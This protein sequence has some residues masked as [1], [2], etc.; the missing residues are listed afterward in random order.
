RLGIEIAEDFNLYLTEAAPWKIA[1]TDP[2]RA[3]AVCSA[4]IEACMITAAILA[5]VLPA[6]AAKV[7]RMLGLSAPL[8][9][10][11]GAAP[12]G[13]GR[14]IHAYE[15]LAEPLE[16][17]KLAAIVD[18]S[19]ATIAGGAAAEG[20]AEAEAEAEG[21]AEAAYEVPPLASEV[22]I[23]AFTGIDLRV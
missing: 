9:C 4:V 5:P 16:P 11:N 14:K 20:E 8:D 23:D 13:A 17:A 22:G 10:V 15:T 2:E 19:E 12:L 7:E 6:W 18:A 21:G 1:G 3:R